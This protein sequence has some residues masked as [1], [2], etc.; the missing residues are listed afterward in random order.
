MALKSKPQQQI[1]KHVAKLGIQLTR[2]K[3][4]QR[5]SKHNDK[6]K[7]HSNKLEIQLPNEITRLTK[8]WF[9]ICCCVICPCVFFLQG[10]IGTQI[11]K[12]VATGNGTAQQQKGKTQCGNKTQQT[13]CFRICRQGETGKVDSNAWDAGRQVTER[14][15]NPWNPQI[16]ETKSRTAKLQKTKNKAQTKGKAQTRKT[17]GV[18]SQK[19]KKLGNDGTKDWT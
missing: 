5:I 13:K 16:E 7:G 3:T 2:E 14:K 9:S 1:E 18:K 19:K 12:R 4:K 17:R 11:N 8:R 6:K 10:Q 15:A